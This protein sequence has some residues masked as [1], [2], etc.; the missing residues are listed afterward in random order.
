MDLFLVT[1]ASFLAGCVDAIVGGGG[2]IMVPALFAAFPL[3]QPAT[4]F[5]TNK[6]VSIWGT[7][8]A[9]AQY[10]QRVQLPWRVLVPAIAFSFVGAIGGAWWLTLVSPDRLRLILPVVLVGVFIYTLAKKDLGRHHAPR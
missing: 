10:S 1:F 8:M 4:L 7:A 3:A 5:G 6:S 2:L 9:A